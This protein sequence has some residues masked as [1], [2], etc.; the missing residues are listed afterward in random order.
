MW[1]PFLWL[2]ASNARVIKQEPQNQPETHFDRA[3]LSE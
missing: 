1:K 2:R 3:K